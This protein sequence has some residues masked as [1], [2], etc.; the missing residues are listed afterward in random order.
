VE[1]VPLTVGV[2]ELSHT[3]SGDVEEVECLMREME[4]GLGDVL[5]MSL[6]EVRAQYF[7]DSDKGKDSEVGWNLVEEQNYG[8]V[9]LSY[10][11]DA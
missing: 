9:I 11:E 7:R 10:R 1:V 8:D 5:G 2:E 6:S 4:L 3:L